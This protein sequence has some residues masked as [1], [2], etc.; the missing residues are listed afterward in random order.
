MAAYTERE[1]LLLL[2]DLVKRLTAAAEAAGG[3]GA[4]GGRV[5]A[6]VAALPHL[7]RLLTSLVDAEVARLKRSDGGIFGAVVSSEFFGK[8]LDMFHSDAKPALC[9]QLLN[10]MVTVPGKIGDAVVINSCVPERLMQ[11][12]RNVEPRALLPPPSPC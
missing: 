4:G 6:P 7:Q 3:V 11:R 9:K 5:L 1:V 8:L 12:P 10:A 2:G